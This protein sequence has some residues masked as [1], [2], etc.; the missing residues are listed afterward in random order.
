MEY[1]NLKFC[2]KETLLFIIAYNHT[3][4]KVLDLFIET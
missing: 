4:K 2:I 3:Q 1:L